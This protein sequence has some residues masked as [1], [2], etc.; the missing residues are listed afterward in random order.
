MFGLASCSNDDFEGIAAGDGLKLEVSIPGEFGTRVF[1]DGTTATELQ[2]AVFDATG[3]TLLMSNVE[4]NGNAYNNAYNEEISVGTFTAG[5]TT[6]TLPLARSQQYKIAFWAAAP[7]APYTFTPSSASVAID[8]SGATV[9]DESRDAFFA[10]DTFTADGTVHPVTLKRPFAQV[11]VGTDD[12]AA[13]KLANLTV[14]SAGLTFSSLSTHLQLMTGNTYGAAKNVTFA[15]KAPATAEAFPV[16]GY[17]YLAMAYVLPPATSIRSKSILDNVTLSVNGNASF[18]TFSNIPVMGNYRTN[19]YGSLL[20]TKE[21]FNVT[22][23]EQYAG[24]YNKDQLPW[25]EVAV[26]LPEPDENNVILIN[27]PEELA[28]VAKSV[29]AKDGKTDGKIIRLNADL[30]L[31]NRP[32]T[33]IGSYG[34]GAMLKAEFDGQGHTIKNL[35]VDCDESAALIGY[36]W[37]STHDLTIDGAEIHSH[38]WAGV[39]FGATTDHANG[40]F[41]NLTVRNA[42]VNVTP[43]MV[44]GKMDNGD[45]AGA[46]AGYVA[47]QSAGIEMT[48]C[49]V[50][51]CTVTAFRDAGGIG[52]M[53]QLPVKNCSVSNT[54]V[55]LNGTLDA[56]AA[57]TT[58]PTTV[59]AIVGRGANSANSGNTATA[60]TLGYAN[61]DKAFTNNTLSAPAG[62]SYVVEG[63][64]VPALTLNLQAGANVK[65][66]GNTVTG[67]GTSTTGTDRF[68]VYVNA[69][70]AG[71]TLTIENNDF[72]ASQSHSIYIQ[73]GNRDAT[74]ITV[75]GNKFANWGQ[76]E[77]PSDA[78]AGS[79]CFKIFQ[80]PNYTGTVENPTLA[81][82]PTLGRSLYD[83]F[84]TTNTWTLPTGAAFGVIQFNK[85]VFK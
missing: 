1:S 2:V 70:A 9:N 15:A 64:T 74:A 55:T 43:E 51:N 85:S 50:E 16:D 53:L 63:C 73:G 71:Y 28:A 75:T 48:N 41:R 36:S 24:S 12:V 69:Q 84:M 23:E 58:I 18:N 8:Y 35:Y 68:G 3:K 83:S 66:S 61:F 76:K 27:T 78:T 7:D 6:V 37:R 65:F 25:Q 82:L 11:N 54:T 4:G 62:S 80:V 57:S 14:T 46:I 20:T 29:N 19:I 77:D 21:L 45:K 52:G 81:E 42:S 38:H 79:C 17:Q 44:D 49:V 67:I 56:D 22:I 72:K 26:S 33:P 39:V 47:G 32:W 40:G 10:A 59:A 30:D 5:K 60:V 13:A 31:Q 34:K